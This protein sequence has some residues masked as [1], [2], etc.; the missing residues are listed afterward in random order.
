[1]THRIALCYPV[2]ETIMVTEQERQLIRDQIVALKEAGSTRVE[3]SQ[4]IGMVM[5]RVLDFYDDTIFGLCKCDID[6]R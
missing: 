5:A 3:T 6:E 2:V 4:Q 1:M